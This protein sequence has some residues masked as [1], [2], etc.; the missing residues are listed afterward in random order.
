MDGEQKHD[1]AIREVP[2]KRDDDAMDMIRYFAMSYKN[3]ED[4]TQL[5]NDSQYFT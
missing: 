4:D 5:P 1:G 2:L 3:D